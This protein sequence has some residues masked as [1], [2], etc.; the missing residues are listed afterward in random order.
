MI[1]DEII[2]KI[3]FLNLM[4]YYKDRDE[5]GGINYVVNV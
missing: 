2:V 3:D 1:F 5:T 4:I